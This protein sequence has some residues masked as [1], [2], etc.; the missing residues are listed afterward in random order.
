MFPKTQE[1][2]FPEGADTMDSSTERFDRRKRMR[3]RGC[4]TLVA[5]IGVLWPYMFSIAGSVETTFSLTN[6]TRYYLHANVNNETFVYISPG[7]T[8][9]VNVKAPA[10]IYARVRYS[11]GQTVKGAGERT[12]DIQSTTTSTE[13]SS[14][15]TDSG[16][17]NT[18]SS[19][20]PTSTTTASPARWDVL[21]ADLTAE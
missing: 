1:M 6:R 20:E 16:E 10:S 3:L 13:G 4:A 9:V 19:T 17:D 15:C 18:C 12:V 14:T 7:G 5:V 11:P 21:P 8:I 2:R